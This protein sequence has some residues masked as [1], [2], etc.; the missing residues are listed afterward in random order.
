L[1]GRE[2]ERRPPLARKELVTEGMYRWI[3]NPMY[4]G[5]LLIL[6]GEAVWFEAL[7]LLAYALVVFMCFHTFNLAYEE[8][9][10]KRKFGASDTKYCLAVPR[11]IPRRKKAGQP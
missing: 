9:T 2:K 11:W 7:I 4:A 6:F 10:L 8:P 3:Q 5:I 1:H